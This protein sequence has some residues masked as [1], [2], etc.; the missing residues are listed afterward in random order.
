MSSSEILKR[1]IG[2]KESDTDDDD[3]AKKVDRD[4]N[5]LDPKTTSREQSQYSTSFGF[6]NDMKKNTRK[7]SLS[8]DEMNKENKGI[9][10][11]A[12]GGLIMIIR[13]L[14]VLNFV[15]SSSF[16]MFLV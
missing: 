4:A 14:L 6:S 15:I 10:N 16:W 3:E 7:S 8:N 9:K 11:R 12:S 1:A 5:S 2:A 13:F